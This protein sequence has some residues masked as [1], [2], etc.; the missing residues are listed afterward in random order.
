MML[1]DRE[2]TLGIAFKC[3]FTEGSYHPILQCC[4]CTSQH[5]GLPCSH[6]NVLLVDHFA[7]DFVL[8]GRVMVLNLLPTLKT[9]RV[10][11]IHK[12]LGCL[13]F[14]HI[15]SYSD[16]YSLHSMCS[17]ENSGFISCLKVSR[18]KREHTLK[19]NIYLDTCSCRKSHR[20]G[21]A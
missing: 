2:E 5:E 9:K 18:V 13:K 19:D 21:V 4:K 14:K 6:L 11:M 16:F 8:I 3:F 15:T 7:M 20:G 12:T 17:T 10:A 1:T